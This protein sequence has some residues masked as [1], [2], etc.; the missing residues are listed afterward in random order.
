MTHSEQIAEIVL[1]MGWKRSATGWISPKSGFT[2]LECELSTIAGDF[3]RDLDA[4][5]EAEKTLSVEQKKCYYQE[6]LHDV[7]TRG[8][9]GLTI[10]DV[11][12][13]QIHATA[14]QRAEAFLRIIKK[15]TA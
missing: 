8:L 2:Y 10:G 5:H 6:E 3:T 7:V 4:M 11:W 15:R 14:A 1:A 9:E 13:L 12:Y